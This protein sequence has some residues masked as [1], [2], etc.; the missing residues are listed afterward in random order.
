MSAP[1]SFQFEG[2][3]KLLEIW[4]TPPPVDAEHLAPP[5][6]GAKYG[7]RRINRVVWEEMLDIVKCKIL[8]VVEGSETDAYLLRSVAPLPSIVDQPY[9]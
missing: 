2:A 1:E 6:D 5:T 9:V 3:E 4:F 7:L 8:S